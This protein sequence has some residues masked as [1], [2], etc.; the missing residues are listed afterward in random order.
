M[1]LG[2]LNAVHITPEIVCNTYEVSERRLGN[3][4]KRVFMTLHKETEGN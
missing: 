1:G 2:A 4:L 3:A